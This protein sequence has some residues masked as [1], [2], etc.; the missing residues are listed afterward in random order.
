MPECKEITVNF[1]NPQ[2][3]LFK[4]DSAWISGNELKT[5]LFQIDA[6]GTISPVIKDIK[7]THVSPFSYGAWVMTFCAKQYVIF[8]DNT[9]I[10]LPYSSH[11]VGEN[12]NGDL[13][14]SYQTMMF[15]IKKGSKTIQEIPTKYENGRIQGMSGNIALI[16]GTTE[17][18]PLP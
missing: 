4:G 6:Q 12:E 13:F 10:E 14:F 3:L 11:L 2:A 16:Y 7:I 9:Y 5:T 1:S 17:G 18:E 15:T 8:L